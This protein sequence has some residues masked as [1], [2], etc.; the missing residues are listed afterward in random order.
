LKN[1]ELNINSI[2]CPNCRKEYNKA[3]KEF[4]GENIENLC[5]DCKERYKI[6]PMR[7]LDCKVESCKRILK[8]APLML[9]YL[10]DD[11][12]DH[13]ENLQS[14]LKEAGFNFV[15]NP[16]IVRGLDYYTK[17]AFEII[18]NDIGAQGTVCG[19]GRYDGLVEEC[20]GPSIP[21]VGFGL[22]LERLLL[23]LENSGIEIPIPKRPDLFICTIGDETKKYA[24]S[25]ATKLRGLGVSVEIDNIGRS[26]KAQMKYANKLNVRYTIILGEDELKNGKVKMKDMDTG[27]ENAIELDK[28][29]DKISE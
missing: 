23:T 21:G 26:L 20:G 12:K 8:D 27:E 13:F 28:I 3:L 17:T 14:Y 2:G 25:M 10:C 9:N 11:C 1:L 16:K 22:G 5:D 29:Y 6:N 15:I 19:G 18:S 4:L 7:V 24:F